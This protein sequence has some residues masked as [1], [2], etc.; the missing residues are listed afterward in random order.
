MTIL[1]GFPHAAQSQP[2]TP[3]GRGLLQEQ[4][5]THTSYH[6]EHVFLG[7]AENKL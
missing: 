1:V 7:S 3:T 6:T 4:G 5:I 2:C